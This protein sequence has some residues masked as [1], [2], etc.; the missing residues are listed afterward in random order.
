MSD[1]CGDNGEKRQDGAESIE[2]NVGNC[3]N[4]DTKEENNK[5]ELNTSTAINIE[6]TSS[7]EC[8]FFGSFS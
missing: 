6:T 5:R 2:L 3:C 4:P 7:V 1:T 8:F